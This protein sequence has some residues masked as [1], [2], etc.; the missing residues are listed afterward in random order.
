MLK[1]RVILKKEAGFTLLE[2]LIAM[3]VFSLAV[4]AVIDVFLVGMGGG[5]KVFGRQ[6]IQ[7]S[8]RFI[9]ETMSKEIRM[10]RINTA[11]GG[12]YSSVNITNAKTP[13]QTLNYS[14]DAINKT[15]SRA[16]DILN[17]SDV[18]VTGSFYVQRPAADVQPRVT[19]V[20]TLKNRTGKIGER[21]EINLQTTISSRNYLP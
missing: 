6:D 13:P 18:E 12:P 17:P 2:L 7:E 19:V 11:A 3:A 10:S 15:I 9:M 20:L 21:A 14:I 5:K 8:G 4:I 16:S 1:R